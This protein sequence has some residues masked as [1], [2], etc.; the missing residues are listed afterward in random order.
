MQCL[1]A[2]RIP[3]L[4]QTPADLDAFWRGFKAQLDEFRRIQIPYLGNLTTLCHLFLEL[5][6]DCAKPDTIVMKTAQ[7]LQ[8]GG[9]TS[10]MSFTDK[11]RRK[12][13]RL[14]QLY[15]LCRGIRTQVVD[16]YFLIHGGQTGAREY[17]QSDFY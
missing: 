9:F 1:N 13:V 4:I 16:L 7:D 17:V 14:M 3:V 8:L 6:Y 12:T 10:A 15:T 5:G 2:K 11:R